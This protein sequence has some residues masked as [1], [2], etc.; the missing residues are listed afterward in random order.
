MCEYV[1][2]SVGCLM[3]EPQP[4][5]AAKLAS[6]YLQLMQVAVAGCSGERVLALQETGTITLP[7]LPS[8]HLSPILLSLSLCKYMGSHTIHAKPGSRAGDGREI[9]RNGRARAWPP[10]A[11][12]MPSPR[13]KLVAITPLGG[14]GV[15]RASGIRRA[16]SKHSRTGYQYIRTPP[17]PIR[18]EQIH[19]GIGWPRCLLLDQEPQHS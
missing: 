5:Q 15:R 10:C 6:A 1:L 11:C 16:S 19:G 14:K 7:V 9:S 4:A 8:H 18:T 3:R 2:F 17:N 12:V 13:T